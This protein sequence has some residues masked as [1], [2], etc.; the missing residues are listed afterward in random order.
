MANSYFD[1]KD[2]EEIIDTKSTKNKV[3]VPAIYAILPILPIVLLIVFSEFFPFFE[4]PI[5]LDTTTVMFI[6]LFVALIFETIRL[7]SLKTVL[8]SLQKA[9]EAA[10][11]K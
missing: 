3:A 9:A 8:N 2:Q 7:K 6:S 4:P 1:K 5:K 10:G 11:T